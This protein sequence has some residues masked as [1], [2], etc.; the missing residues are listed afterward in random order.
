[1]R[2][3]T[4]FD[5]SVPS[6]LDKDTKIDSSL[7]SETMLLIHK[8]KEEVLKA[9]D[10]K[11]VLFLGPTGAGKS[12]AIDFL[13]G[14]E[15][16]GLE[17]KTTGDFQIGAKDPVV[18][19]GDGAQSKTLYPN[20][21]KSKIDQ[22]ILFCDTAGFGDN[23]GPKYDIC[24]AY[25]LSSIFEYAKEIH[26][27]VVLI[28][29]E[30]L[31]DPR[32]PKLLSTFEQLNRLI[33]DKNNYKA[34]FLFV[35]TKTDKDP[36]TEKQI[37]NL[38][39]KRYQELTQPQAGTG[40]LIDI[41]RISWLFDELLANEGGSIKFCDPIKPVNATGKN[42]VECRQILLD[43]ISKLKP[44]L[45]TKQAFS[46]PISQ[47]SQL[48]LQKLIDQSDQN[49]S[50]LVDDLRKSYSEN[51]ANEIE[52]SKQSIEKLS[53]LK[54][55]IIDVRKT[56]DDL[57][58]GFFIQSLFSLSMH[59]GPARGT[60]KEASAKLRDQLN[61][62]DSL[63]HFLGEDNLKPKIM[64][65]SIENFNHDFTRC[66]QNIDMYSVKLYA[67][68]LRRLLASK[69]IQN[70]VW[71][72]RTKMQN[73]FDRQEGLRNIINELKPYFTQEVSIQ[74]QNLTDNL[75]SIKSNGESELRAAFRQY[76]E[77]P[78]S[79]PET[80]MDISAKVITIRANAQNLALSQVL[81]ALD[82]FKHQFKFE[83]LWLLASGTLIVDDNLQNT[84]MG[85]KNLVMAAAQ[86]EVTK[87][88][89]KIDVSG[90][91]LEQK[92]IPGENRALAGKSA[93]NIH[94]ITTTE[95][96]GYPLHLFANGSSGGSGTNGRNGD[97]GSQGKDGSD[98]AEPG[99]MGDLILMLQ[100]HDKLVRGSAGSPGGPGEPGGLAGQ[101]G[102]GGHKGTVFTRPLNLRNLI[103]AASNGGKGPDGKPGSGGPGG[104]GG[105]NGYDILAIKAGSQFETDWFRGYIGNYDYH[106]KFAVHTFEVSGEYTYLQGGNS[107]PTN[108]PTRTFAATGAQGA[109][110]SVL[111]NAQLANPAILPI[112]LD[113]IEHVFHDYQTS[114]KP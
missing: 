113:E 66:L 65:A 103:S 43:A 33:P 18:E 97:K 2:S 27:V 100:A 94:L 15:M 48:I 53:A 21:V 51:L 8:G 22:K 58:K 98:A 95:I 93:G 67:L 5:I 111:A 29:K 90:K 26:G 110:G 10:Q 96:I 79:Y 86:L 23:R 3:T 36:R 74:F 50:D 106:N 104:R 37:F 114:F 109:D 46:Y 12:T 44:V 107:P 101:G 31:I 72:I 88:N 28:Q 34:S 32:L 54:K 60:L 64:D 92:E 78:F 49:I 84:L 81:L 35:V 52:N 59:F 55:E 68:D 69:P 11:I 9:T 80:A 77:K 39:T 47:D 7:L 16:Y 20:I 87:E 63:R 56:L 19:I 45:E 82:P 91:A 24:A 73:Y 41:S 85:G 40:A 112:S 71:L 62:L 75:F 1:M 61:I 14:C 102:P 70:Q 6:G 13:S 76:L 83:A 25:T 4:V 99:G 105:Q 108:G 38:L 57:G 89:L 30:D 42:N 17:D